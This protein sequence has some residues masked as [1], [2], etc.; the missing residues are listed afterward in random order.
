MPGVRT[1]R[2]RFML[3][4]PYA[5]FYEEEHLADLGIP[6]AFARTVVDREALVITAYQQ[7]ANRLRELARGDWQTRIAVTGEM[8]SDRDGFDVRVGLIASSGNSRCADRTWTFRF[9]RG[10]A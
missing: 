8:T 6:D 2:S 4:E 1:Y 10:S 7:A 3:I 5:M 9:A